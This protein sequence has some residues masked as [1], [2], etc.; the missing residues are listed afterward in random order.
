M[1]KSDLKISIKIMKYKFKNSPKMD[2]A[3]TL[4]FAV[5]FMIFLDNVLLTS[6]S[7]IV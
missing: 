6:I 3:N 2:R 4:L 7:K 1:S 5:F